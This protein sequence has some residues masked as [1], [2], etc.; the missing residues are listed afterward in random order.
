MKIFQYPKE[1]S[2]DVLKQ[3]RLSVAIL[4]ITIGWVS[5]DHECWRRSRYV[6]IRTIPL[7]QY[8]IYRPKPCLNTCLSR[9]AMRKILRFNE[10]TSDKYRF[11]GIVA[12]VLCVS[13]ASVPVAV[14]FVFL[15]RG[16]G[17][18]YNAA[19]ER[20]SSSRGD[21]GNASITRLQ[22]PPWLYAWRAF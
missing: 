17:F 10:R 8:P 5:E 4:A 13:K 19:C 15:L 1:E 9:T 21:L 18:C 12:F 6:C 2:V 7:D 20:L 11:T 3:S 16:E 14:L 22:P